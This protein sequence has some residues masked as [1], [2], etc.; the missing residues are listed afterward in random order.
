MSIV[1]SKQQ[2]SYY[3]EIAGVGTFVDHTNQRLKLLEHQGVSEE[4]IKKIISFARQEGLG[5][6]ITN[7]HIRLLAPFTNSGFVIEGIINR[8]YQGEDAFCVSYFLDAKRGKASNW[9]KEEAILYQ[10]LRDTRP[11]MPRAHEDYSIRQATVHDIPQMVRLFSSVFSTY[12]SPVFSGQYLKQV[13]SQHVLFRVAEQDG[14]VVS[15]A[16]AEMNPGNLNAEITDCATYPAYRGRAIL[17]SLIHCLE[18][19]LKGKGYRTGYSLARAINPGINKAFSR[20]GYK[21]SGR[22]VNNCHICGEYED[23]NIWVKRLS[24]G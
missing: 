15:V 14:R 24:D 21:F 13:M 17:S 12:P 5:K 2:E 10:C 20:L 16:S 8:F 3:L 23:M 7:C 4:S 19:D 11:F 18:A 6:I 1:Q 22:L 9:K